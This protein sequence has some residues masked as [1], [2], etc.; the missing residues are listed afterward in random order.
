VKKL[1]NGVPLLV[2]QHARGNVES[3]LG[4]AV[5]AH[6]KYAV[7]RNPETG[8]F[9][10]EILYEASAR[11]DAERATTRR[12][13]RGRLARSRTL[14]ESE[15]E[16]REY[17]DD[18]CVHRQPFPEPVPEEREIDRHDHGNHQD[19]VEYRGLLTSHFS[20]RFSR[21]PLRLLPNLTPAPRNVAP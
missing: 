5:E 18:S 1:M 12:A 9:G 10:D 20:L 17:Q 21:S 2:H 6:A 19:Y 3:A 14:Q 8:L 15:V 11:N 16:G 7:L 13:P 4:E